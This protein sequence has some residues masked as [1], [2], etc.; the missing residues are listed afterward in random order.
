MKLRH[1][2]HNQNIV[3][4]TIIKTIHNLQVIDDWS[5]DVNKNLLWNQENS[6]SNFVP[7]RRRV[8]PDRLVIHTDHNVC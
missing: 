1:R 2:P 5:K 6:L 3:I 8:H 4:G 7:T